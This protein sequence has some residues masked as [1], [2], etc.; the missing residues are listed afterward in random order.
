M[1]RG[2][3]AFA[4]LI[5]AVLVAAGC[6]DSPTPQ[7]VGE[8]PTATPPVVYGMASVKTATPSTAP[9]PTIARASPPPA[10]PSPTS[11]V[12]LPGAT[13]TRATKASPQPAALSPTPDARRSEQANVPRIGVAEAKAKVEAGEA[14]LVDVRGTTTYEAQHIAGA[15]S[16]PASQVSSR[17]I[18]LPTD[19]LIIFYCA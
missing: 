18:E 13:V 17:Y 14:I 9:V 4:L 6:G 11:A 8:R 1:K 19:K 15:I 2:L 3:I 12:I 16:M 5:G 7:V 10:R